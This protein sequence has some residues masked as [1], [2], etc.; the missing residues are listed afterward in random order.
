MGIQLIYLNH[1]PNDFFLYQNLSYNENKQK[2]G[3]KK[4]SLNHKIFFFFCSLPLLLSQLVFNLLRFI[5]LYQPQN[6]LVA[7]HTL[8]EF[9]FRDFICVTNSNVNKTHFKI[10]VYLWDGWSKNAC[11]LPFSLFPKKS[12]ILSDLFSGVFSS[13][14]RF[15]WSSAGIIWNI[16]CMIQKTKKKKQEHLNTGVLTFHIENS[17]YFFEIN[18]NA[19]DVQ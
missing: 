13:S 11:G 7:H 3:M 2:Q 18:L 15:F 16:D 6:V 14:G 5:I 1:F 17:K 12:Q 8:N 4:K 9:T 19:R 10:F